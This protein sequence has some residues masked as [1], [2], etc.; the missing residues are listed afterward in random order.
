[1]AHTTCRVCLV[2][3]VSSRCK[4]TLGR[5]SAFSWNLK[6]LEQSTFVD[7][8]DVMRMFHAVNSLFITRNLWLILLSKI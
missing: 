1:M 8:Y 3:T 5:V 4:K 6:I 7:I 2:S